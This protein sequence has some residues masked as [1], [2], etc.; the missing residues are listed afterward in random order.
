MV[1]FFPNLIVEEQPVNPR[2]NEA[3]AMF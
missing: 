1:G 2:V 3:S